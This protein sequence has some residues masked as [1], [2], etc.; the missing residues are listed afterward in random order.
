MPPPRRNLPVNVGMP[1]SSTF[2]SLRVI[3]TRC[4]QQLLLKRGGEL[5]LTRRQPQAC[6][7]ASAKR[8]GSSPETHIPPTTM[9]A[10]SP[11][12]SVVGQATDQSVTKTMI[13]LMLRQ[14]HTVVQQNASKS[15]PVPLKYGESCLNSLICHLGPCG[16]VS[17]AWFWCPIG[18]G[19]VS[20]QDQCAYLPDATAR[21]YDGVTRVVDNC[22]NLTRG[23]K[24]LWL[25]R[26]ALE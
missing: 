26:P 13:S 16:N 2:A 20:R 4:C 10:E 23:A 7:I 24:P 19:D 15:Q 6:L 3:D 5:S 18:P 22:I 12:R 25:L 9:H 8:I 1:C 14:S 11:L 17:L 21:C